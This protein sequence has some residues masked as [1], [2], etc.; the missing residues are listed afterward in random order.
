MPCS[1]CS[2]IHKLVVRFQFRMRASRP[3]PTSPST[4][5]IRPNHNP[6]ISPLDTAIRATPPVP[7]LVAFQLHRLSLVLGLAVALC[8]G[9]RCSKE[10]GEAIDPRGDRSAE[11]ARKGVRG[12]PAK[13]KHNVVV[14]VGK[15]P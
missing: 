12:A 9:G 14:C 8:R 1:V 4:R 7:H 2:L 11:S 13:F 3:G 10:K 5:P 6:A 15:T